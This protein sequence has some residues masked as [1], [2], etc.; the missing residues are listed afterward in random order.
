MYIVS[1]VIVHE[2]FEKHHVY[3]CV[4]LSMNE[5][6]K[7]RSN[8]NV[9]NNRLPRNLT[10]SSSKT[11]GLITGL[12]VVLASSV[13]VHCTLFRG[14]K[15]ALQVQ[16]MF[17][18]VLAGRFTWFFDNVHRQSVPIPL[19]QES[20]NLGWI[21]IVNWFLKLL[22]QSQVTWGF[23]QLWKVLDLYFPV[24]RSINLFHALPSQCRHANDIAPASSFR[25]MRFAT[26]SNY[27]IQV[28]TKMWV[29]R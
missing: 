6:C 27:T 2:W 29:K 7:D 21:L 14:M 16:M 9:N 10:N 17:H 20:R 4:V 11:C 22:Y 13:V 26:L 28:I 15:T 18:N 23:F 5:C 19:L 25:A 24:Y 8:C 3:V 1:S 12:M